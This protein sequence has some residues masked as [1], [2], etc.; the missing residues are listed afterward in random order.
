ME[1]DIKDALAAQDT[2]LAYQVF[3]NRFTFTPITGS[4]WRA[5]KAQNQQ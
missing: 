5:L 2:V 1:S 4:E 3:N